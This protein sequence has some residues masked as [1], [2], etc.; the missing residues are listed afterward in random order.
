MRFAPKAYRDTRIDTVHQVKSALKW[1]ANLTDITLDALRQNPSVLPILRMTTAPP[2]ARD[3]LIGL[4]GASP[5][6]VKS[7][8]IDRRIS[9][10][11]DSA[12]VETDLQK[13]GRII[14]R[15]IDQDIFPWLEDKRKPSQVEVD[16]AATIVA[17]RL[18]GAMADPIIRNA[19]EQR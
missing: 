14:M 12:M 3:R 17:D 11:M 9:T 19:Q 8:E 18:C 16:R 2:I 7:M 13:I 15:L 1:T 10:R 6:L 5:G 4:A